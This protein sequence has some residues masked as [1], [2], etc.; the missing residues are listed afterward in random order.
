MGEAVGGVLAPAVG[1]ALSPIPIVGV[2]LMLSTPKG[3]TNGLAFGLGWFVGLAAVSTVVLTATAG[4]DSSSATA[5]GTG[6][7]LVAFGVV[8]AV[9]GVRQWRKR[10]APGEQP[11]L[12]GWIDAVDHFGPPKALGLGLLLSAAN[13]KN[14]AL[15]VAA[16]ASISQT[17]AD[18]ADAVAAELV[19]LV[20]ASSTVVGLVLVHLVA[21]ARVADG[22]DRLKTTMA[23]HSAVIMAVICWVLAAKL[24]G[25][26]TGGLTG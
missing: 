17:G 16:A 2:V 3:R 24:I 7:A 10:P 14:L 21:G 1:V 6:T 22:L 26:G 11:E 13:P 25:D 8:L 23:N 5:D 20:I 15:T 18:G 4:A 9:V 19:F 12:P